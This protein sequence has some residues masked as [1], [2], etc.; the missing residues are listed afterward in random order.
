MAN[1]QLQDLQNEV[2]MHLGVSGT[3]L[4]PSGNA[5]STDVLRWLN[6]VQ[7]DLCARWPWPFM[8]GSEQVATVADY[9]TGTV[10]ISSGSTSGTGSGTTFTSTQGNGQY[11]IQFAGTNDWYNFTYVSATSFTTDKPYQP[12]TNATNVAYILRKFYYSLSSSADR[13]MNLVNW[14][15]PVKMVQVDLKTMTELN[16]LAQATNTSYA[17]VPWGYD[18]SGNIQF[19]PYPFPSDA[20]II[21]VKTMKRPVDMANATDSPS[22]P[23]KYAHLIAWGAI[24]IGYAFK[25]K[26]FLEL[27]QSWSQK[28]EQR[29]T[30]MRSEYRMSEDS[31][32]C[33]RSIDSIQRS[34][35]IQFP[36]QWPT[37]VG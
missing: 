21:Q 29:L 24:A 1:L 19:I 18:S 34:K 3:S 36:G 25:G 31:E 17:Y 35:W 12:T 33:L 20:R 26:E 16:P 13:I 5:Y 2:Y 7:Q 32:P 6:Y 11:Y 14:N 10:S 15:T 28:F 27:A 4:D 30:Q 9:T 37:L 22:I 23:N 8:E